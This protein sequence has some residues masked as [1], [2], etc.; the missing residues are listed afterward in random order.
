MYRT[1]G[2]GGVAA[3]CDGGRRPRPLISAV[4]G[5]WG[6]AGRSSLAGG[7][8][9]WFR[10]NSHTNTDRS[11]ELGCWPPTLWYLSSPWITPCADMHMWNR[12]GRDPDGG[13]SFCFLQ[14]F[15][16]FSYLATASSRHLVF[17]QLCDVNALL[18]LLN[19]YAF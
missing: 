14:R 18:D 3:F 16:S 11:I 6:R 1:V 12:V 13:F 7:P 8:R 10:P 5:V 17:S 19:F 15:Y 2:A 4:A 9:C